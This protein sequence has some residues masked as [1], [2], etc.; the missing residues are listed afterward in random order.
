VRYPDDSKRPTNSKARLA[1]RLALP[2][3]G[4]K[5]VKP[6]WKLVLDATPLRC[7]S[8]IFFARTNKDFRLMHQFSLG[9]E[10]LVGIQ[11]VVLVGVAIKQVGSH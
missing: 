2:H 3:P 9:V 7:A 5:D 10:I 11:V 8:F 4:Q 6:L 1:G